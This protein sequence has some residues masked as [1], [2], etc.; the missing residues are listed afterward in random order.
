VIF[1]G[2]VVVPGI[3][4][5]AEANTVGFIIGG[6]YM[7]PLLVSLPLL[8]AFVVERQ[9]LNARQ[10]HSM[11][12]LMCVALLPTHLVLLVFGMVRWQSGTQFTH[13]NPFGGS[14]HPPT[15]SVA[16]LVLMIAGLLLVGWMTWTAPPRAAAHSDLREDDPGA[17]PSMGKP[18]D[19]QE[20]VLTSKVDGRS[21]GSGP[22]GSDHHP[23]NELVVPR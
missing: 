17:E 4:Q 22:S 9:V 10:S 7:L 3:L 16:P 12:K 13:L 19:G 23:L 18:E 14:W 6:R 15:G 21:N 1:I 20:P 8:G 2:G 5:V 11:T